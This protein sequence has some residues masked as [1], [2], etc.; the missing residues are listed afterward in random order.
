MTS[1]VFTVQKH[2]FTAIC[3][4]SPL[5]PVQVLQ[6]CS[7]FRLAWK[8]GWRRC[9]GSTWRAT[10]GPSSKVSLCNGCLLLLQMRKTR[11]CPIDPVAKS[12]L[13]VSARAMR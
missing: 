8:S 5:T 13:V 3:M 10:T 12:E 6:P 11:K 2:S 1:Y 7:G 4:L 9:S